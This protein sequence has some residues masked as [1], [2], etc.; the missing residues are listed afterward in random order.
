MVRIFPIPPRK[1][2]N[3]ILSQSA[4][5]YFW[6]KNYIKIKSSLELWAAFNFKVSFYLRFVSM[7]YLGFNVGI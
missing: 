6:K 7:G 3:V 4:K 5:I 1:R 2:M